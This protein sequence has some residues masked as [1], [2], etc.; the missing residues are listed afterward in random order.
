MMGIIT[1][2]ASGLLKVNRSRLINI[3]GTIS[4]SDVNDEEEIDIKRVEALEESSAIWPTA[5][6]DKMVTNPSTTE[7]ETPSQHYHILSQPPKL[8]WKTDLSYRKVMG[9]M[10]GLGWMKG[11][12]ISNERSMLSFSPS[13]ES[14]YIKHFKPLI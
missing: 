6:Y 14:H 5:L 4:L 2:R 1:G 12:R 7:R 11:N 8:D 3:A 9:V 13:D 10:G